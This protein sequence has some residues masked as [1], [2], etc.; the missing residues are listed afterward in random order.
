MS[1]H[2]YVVK[3]K[4]EAIF[5]HSFKRLRLKEV[6]FLTFV[7][8]L[9]HSPES[10]GMKNDFNSWL[11]QERWMKCRFE[12]QKRE[13]ATPGFQLAYTNYMA[14]TTTHL[15]LYKAPFSYRAQNGRDGMPTH[16]EILK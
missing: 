16:W 5:Q 9:N 11:P 10:L 8:L 6:T 13:G 4:E 14:F 7:V 1:T 15:E 3:G 2:V 12:H